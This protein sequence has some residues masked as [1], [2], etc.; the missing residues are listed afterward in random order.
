MPAYGVKGPSLPVTEALMSVSV[1]PRQGDSG[2][3]SQAPC[4]VLEV[5]DPMPGIDPGVVLT[6][7]IPDQMH[8]SRH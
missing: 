6:R 3:L 1:R 8:P 5:V 4:Y 2:V 7:A